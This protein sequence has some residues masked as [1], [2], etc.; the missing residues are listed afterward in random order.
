M[1]IDI[2]CV[3]VYSW[4]GQGAESVTGEM[5]EPPSQSNILKFD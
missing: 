1:D 3:Y 2:A 4:G 5:D